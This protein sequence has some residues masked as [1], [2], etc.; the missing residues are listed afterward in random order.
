MT[1]PASTLYTRLLGLALVDLY[2]RHQR[3]GLWRQS[4]KGDIAKSLDI[5]DGV[6][7]ALLDIM[8]GYGYTEDPSR[9]GFYAISAKG[10]RAAVALKEMME[11]AGG[12]GH[13]VEARRE[14]E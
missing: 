4:R 6:A 10:Q 11:G 12:D 1:E 9:S 2:D 3:L 13:G 8:N 7:G 5:P 14:K